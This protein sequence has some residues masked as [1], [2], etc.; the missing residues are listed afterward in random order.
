MKKLFVAALLVVGITAFAQ[1]K[2]GRRPGKD[3]LTTEQKVDLQV[4]KMT[5]D[6]ELNEKQASEIRVLATKQVE[7]REQRR[8]ELK[9]DKEKDRAERIAAMQKEEAAVGAEMKKILTAEQF[10]KW[11]KIRDERK[12][13]MKEKM[14]DR[15]EKKETK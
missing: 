5:K 13:K 1:E 15:M 11:E 12:E 14:H 10:A 8:A 6:L 9:A 7:K 2:E 4:K 3:R